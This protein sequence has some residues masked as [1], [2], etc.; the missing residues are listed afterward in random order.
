MKKTNV[1]IG[2]VEFWKDKYDKLLTESKNRFNS[3]MENSNIGYFIIDKESK[4]QNVNDAW[5][6]IYKFKSKNDIIGQHYTSL[7]IDED[8]EKLEK[9]FNNVLKT[10]QKH[11]CGEMRH[12]CSDGSIGYHICEAGPV[13]QNGKT[14][15][16]EG[17][18]IDISK[19]KQNEKT[20]LDSHN[21]LYTIL[22]RLPIILFAIDEKGILLLSEGKGLD[23]IGYKKGEV[24]GKSI[25]EVFKD[26]PKMQENI[27]RGLNNEEFRSVIEMGDNVFDTWYQP[28]KKNND[29]VGVIGV[30]IDITE[31]VKLH[32]QLIHSEKIS[33]VGQLAFGVAHEFNNLLA[34]IL[35]N[36]Q[37][38]IDENS[39]EE[40]T[41][42]L[43]T[44]INTVFKGKKIVEN[45]AIFSKSKNREMD[46]EDIT[47]VIDEVLILNKNLFKTHNI[48]L[49]KKYKTHTPIYFNWSQME[50]V[51]SNL[52][53]NAVH[54]VIP[55]AKGQIV[56]SVRELFN[57][58]QIKVIDDGIGMS[59]DTKIKIFEPFFTTKGAF[60]EDDLKIPGTGLGL[61]VSYSIIEQ[62]NGVIMADSKEDRG[63][64]FIIALPITD[65]RLKPSKKTPNKNV[66]DN[67]I[68]TASIM[69]ID[70]EKEVSHIIKSALNKK[71]IKNI[72]IFNYVREALES[73]DT[74]KPEI[75]FLDIVM[76]DMNGVE[77]FMKIKAIIPDIPVV[78]ITGK[79]NIN[80]LKY[81]KMGVSD[82]I[83]KPFS[84]ESMISIIKK[85]LK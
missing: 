63:T 38:A 5:L 50:Q 37:Y 83:S 22:N 39:R 40:V 19:R 14:N 6:K 8:K 16:I 62:H 82:I 61:T 78:F 51:F 70:D 25:Y 74:I 11:V 54:A 17:F 81:K 57:H 3:F 27:T 66:L 31:R 33:A 43:N 68:K 45:L 28:L 29:I 79:L 21:I 73:L 65:N 80:I 48:K 44:I 26:Y 85:V 4:I 69:I 46:Y 13:T 72:S 7:W 15:G 42:S 84:I 23:K 59:E 47:K 55:K 2:T 71:G 75:I 52:V 41:N 12:K 58:I 30:S 76:P 53:I 18:I 36:A 77:A 9:T 34:V 32:E 35:G 60:A 64:I 10:K 24:V 1:K 49:T 67:K 20:L 56:I